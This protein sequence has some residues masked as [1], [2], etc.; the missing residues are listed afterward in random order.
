[1][2][3]RVFMGGYKN[4]MELSR[5]NVRES[6]AGLTVALNGNMGKTCQGFAPR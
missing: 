3:T 6:E 5:N 2:N 1:M 4:L